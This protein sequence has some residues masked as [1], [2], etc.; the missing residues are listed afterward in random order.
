MCFVAERFTRLR[1]FQF[2]NGSNIARIHSWNGDM[3]FALQQD[4][5]SKPLGRALVGVIGLYFRRSRSGIYAEEGYASCERI[6]KRF[7]DERGERLA[8]DDLSLGFLAV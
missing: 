2:R 8:L 3:S 1:L 5:R 6:R 4:N 7:E